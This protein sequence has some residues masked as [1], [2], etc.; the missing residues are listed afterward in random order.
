MITATSN[1]FSI[2]LANQKIVCCHCTQKNI[3]KYLICAAKIGNAGMQ[4]FLGLDFLE[5]KGVSAVGLILKKRLFAL[6]EIT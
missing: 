4:G 2:E 3:Q 6:S 1:L 5:L